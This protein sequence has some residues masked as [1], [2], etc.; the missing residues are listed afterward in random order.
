MQNEKTGLNANNAEKKIPGHG[1]FFFTPLPFISSRHCAFAAKKSILEM[2]SRPRSRRRTAS[3]GRRRS[4]RLR[5]SR[6]H[7]RRSASLRGGTRKRVS[8]RN[9]FRSSRLTADTPRGAA[10]PPPAPPAPPAPHLPP[11]K[12]LPSFQNLEGFKFSRKEDSNFFEM[13]FPENASITYN[14]EKYSIGSKTLRLRNYYLFPDPM[15]FMIEVFAEATDTPLESCFFMRHSLD[16]PAFRGYFYPRLDDGGHQIERIKKED[17]FFMDKPFQYHEGSGSWSFSGGL[18][19][20]TIQRYNKLSDKVQMFDLMR[21]KLIPLK[22]HA[23]VK[24]VF[25]N[26]NSHDNAVF[27]T[28]TAEKKFMVVVYE[29]HLLLDNHARK[30]IGDADLSSWKQNFD[31]DGQVTIVDDSGRIQNFRV[32]DRDKMVID[33][34]SQIFEKYTFTYEKRSSYPLITDDHHSFLCGFLALSKLFDLEQ[35]LNIPNTETPANKL[36]LTGAGV[37][38]MSTFFRREQNA[39]TRYW[40]DMFQDYQKLCVDFSPHELKKIPPFS[41]EQI[42]EWQKE[43]SP[44]RQEVPESTFYG[45]DFSEHSRTEDHMLHPKQWKGKEKVVLEKKAFESV[46]HAMKQLRAQQSP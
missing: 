18:H 19:S 31:D 40:L 32:Q 42:M 44:A 26:Y 5:R 27:I 33:S 29:N 39:P 4:K 14:D 34:M 12:R 11:Q 21:N 36:M 46:G 8:E 43:R 37:M 20:K 2:P 30:N 35:A 6:E 10:P 1:V 16:A 25:S 13:T 24:G 23:T 15:L 7:Q 38:V 28:K 22:V 3:F 9:M 17:K 45:K 41:F